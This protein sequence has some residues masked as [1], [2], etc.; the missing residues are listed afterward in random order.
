MSMDVEVG[1]SNNYGWTIA[2]PY[3]NREVFDGFTTY[4]ADKGSQTSHCTSRSTTGGFKFQY[5]VYSAKSMFNPLFGTYKNVPNTL[6]WTSEYDCYP[7]YPGTGGFTP[8]PNKTI[9]AIWF[10]TGTNRDTWQFKHY[11]IASDYDI[12]YEPVWLPVFGVTIGT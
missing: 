7:T 1:T 8:S 5:A 2:Y 6:K 10:A 4:V 3:Q 11:C 12:M 9:D